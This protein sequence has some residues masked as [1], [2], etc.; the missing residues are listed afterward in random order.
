[1]TGLPMARRFMVYTWVR[2]H[3]RAAYGK[4]VYGVYMGEA[5]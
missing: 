5:T 4:A 1:M 3:D 2:L